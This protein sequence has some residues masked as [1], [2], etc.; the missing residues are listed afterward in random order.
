M[1]CFLSLQTVQSLGQGT[2]LPF[3]VSAASQYAPVYVRGCC[4]LVPQDW[5]DSRP[6]EKGCTGSHC[7]DEPLS[8]EAGG[9]WCCVQ[10]WWS[11]CHLAKLLWTWG[12]VWPLLLCK[13]LVRGILP[14]LGSPVPIWQMSGQ[15]YSL[16]L[17]VGPRNRCKVRM[18]I[19]KTLHS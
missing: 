16:C 11:L 17:A 10:F 4:C 19:G 7:R 6:M 15:N 3:V 14:S 5:Q 8:H 1:C 18:P 12:W 2:I 13:I 9:V